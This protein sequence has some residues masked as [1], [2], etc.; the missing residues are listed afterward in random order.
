MLYPDMGKDTGVKNAI[1]ELVE[2]DLKSLFR[3]REPLP[4]RPSNQL[5]SDVELLHGLWKELGLI[6]ESEP[7]HQPQAF[8]PTHT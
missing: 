1:V 3:S 2:E 7:Q 4:T 8:R 5:P 6:S